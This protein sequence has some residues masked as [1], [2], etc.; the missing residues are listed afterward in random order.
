MLNRDSAKLA[1][2][3]R[4]SA[5]ACLLNMVSILDAGGKTVLDMAA[6][7]SKFHYQHSAS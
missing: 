6:V 7:I 5:C 1:T 3:E 2:T 4:S